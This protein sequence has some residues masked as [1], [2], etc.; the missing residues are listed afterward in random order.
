M[1]ARKKIKSA[2]A[3]PDRSLNEL[4]SDSARLRKQALGTAQ[5]LKELAQAITNA[6]KGSGWR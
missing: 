1:P 4:L 3:K 5:R 2:K 6:A